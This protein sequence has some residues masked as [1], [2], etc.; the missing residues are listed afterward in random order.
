MC[1]DNEQMT[2]KL[3]KIFFAQINQSSSDKVIAALKS[4]KKF[5][6]IDDKLKRLRLEYLL[7]YPQL[8]TKNPYR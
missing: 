7:G 5:L 1:K 3:A 4:V 6:L 2:K 8:M